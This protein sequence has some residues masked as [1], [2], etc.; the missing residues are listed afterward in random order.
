MR[1]SLKNTALEIIEK[2]K[3]QFVETLSQL[4]KTPS[5]NPPGH[6]QEI[7]EFCKNILEKEGLRVQQDQVDKHHTT[8]YF[9]VGSGNPELLLVAHLDT[10]PIGPPNQ[11]NG[12][13]LSGNIEG[14]RIHGRG[15]GSKASL[16]ALLTL[17]QATLQLE[18]QLPYS[19]G[20]ML[21][22]D[23]WNPTFKKGEQIIQ[24]Q[25]QK[26]NNILICEPTNTIKHGHLCIA[27]ELGLLIIQAPIQLNK[28]IRKLSS[29]LPW[30]PTP[31]EARLLAKNATRTLKTNQLMHRYIPAIEEKPDT[32]QLEVK[33]SIPPGGSITKAEKTIINIISPNPYNTI[34]KIPPSHTP[35]SNQFLR[36]IKKTGRRTFGEKTPLTYGDYCGI[37]H[38]FRAEKKIPTASY[39]PGIR[40]ASTN[41][42]EH[43]DLNDALNCTK[44]YATLALVNN[45]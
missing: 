32:Q 26:W 8:L 10:P 22:P 35:A 30:V 43:I 15:A 2:K 21:N 44:A 18:S 34:T 9:E 4:V 39:G 24:N 6:T 19:I 23:G 37:G 33:I 31:Y 36:K 3:K 38:H 1:T 40:S 16:N 42:N 12:N 7:A 41:P 29:S 17:A 5:P 11:W 27:G 28:K 45:L 25:T 13:P 20:F 14:G